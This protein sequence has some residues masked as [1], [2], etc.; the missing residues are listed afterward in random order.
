MSCKSGNMKTAKRALVLTFVLL[1]ISVVVN[2][3]VGFP[4]SYSLVIALGPLNLLIFTTPGP[5]PFAVALA[6]LP[7]STFFIERGR[8]MMAISLS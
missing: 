5:L 4:A 7:M 1:A 3:M 2:L 6:L 8:W